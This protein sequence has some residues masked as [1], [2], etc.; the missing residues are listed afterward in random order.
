[1]TKWSSNNSPQVPVSIQP[2]IAPSKSHLSCFTGFFSLRYTNSLCGQVD[3]RL[4]LR[5]VDLFGRAIDLWFRIIIIPPLTL[6]CMITYYIAIDLQDT[7]FFVGV[8]IAFTTC[9]IN[10]AT[11]RH[12]KY[13]IKDQNS[14]RRI[15]VSIKIKAVCCKE[16]NARITKPV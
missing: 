5:A 1:M 4:L 9:L 6:I 15:D 2:P 7:N 8:P 10:T 11:L 3:Q 12:N 13:S 14:Y 16:T